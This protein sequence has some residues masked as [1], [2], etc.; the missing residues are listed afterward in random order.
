MNQVGIDLVQLRGC[1]KSFMLLSIESLFEVNKDMIEIL[2]MLTILFTYEPQ[3]EYLLSSASSNSEPCLFF[4][5]DVF[6]HRFQSVQDYSE[7]H[8]ARVADKANS[9]II[10]TLLKVSFLGQ[11]DD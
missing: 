9:S 10:L 8:F 6:C 5:N 1:P 11:G 7:H 3:V 2:L 4:S